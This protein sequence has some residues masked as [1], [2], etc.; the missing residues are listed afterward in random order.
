MLSEIASMMKFTTALLQA[1]KYHMG[2][3]AIYIA[4]DTGLSIDDIQT[5]LSHWLRWGYVTENAGL[6]FL[7]DRGVEFIN[8]LS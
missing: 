6:Y 5:R 1:R 7:T 2:I 8:K 3:S 4:S